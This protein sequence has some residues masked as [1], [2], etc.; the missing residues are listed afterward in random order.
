MRRMKWRRSTRCSQMGF[1]LGSS[2][3]GEVRPSDIYDY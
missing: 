3:A 1:D 2:L